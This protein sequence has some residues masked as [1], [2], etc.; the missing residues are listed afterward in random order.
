MSHQ[1]ILFLDSSSIGGIESHVR[2]LATLLNKHCQIKVVLWQQYQAEHPLL[3]Q[4]AVLKV[5]TEVLDGSIGK[6]AAL[7]SNTPGVVLHCHGYKANLI[8][9]LLAVIY[10]VRCVCTFH[11]GDR[12]LGRVR[13]YTWLDEIT[14]IVSRNIAVSKQIAERIKGPSLVMA[15]RVELPADVALSGCRMGPVAFVGRI[16]QV[17][18]PDR[19]CT[20]AKQFPAQQ[21]AIWGDGSLRR[22]LDIQS[23]T[24]LNWHGAVGSMS[25]YWPEIDLLVICSEQEGFP[26]VAL[27][28][29]AAGVPVLALP[30][31]DLP[32]L[33]K[34]GVNGFIADNEVQLQHYLSVWFSLK[35]AERLQMRQNARKCVAQH[36]DAELAWPQLAEIYGIS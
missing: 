1:V 26:M 19:F 17:K 4:L 18:R 25:Y 31:G 14:S 29:M 36:Y 8:G 5:Q 32:T 27:E 9:R 20:L 6:F 7:L 3:Q 16:E 35:S 33:I 24:N 2:T 30:L 12:G 28:A 21:F 23:S 13:F 34:H 15:N 22:Q 11:N 10:R